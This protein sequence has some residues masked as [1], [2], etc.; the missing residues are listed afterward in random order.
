MPK[1]YCDNY[2]LHQSILD[3]VS[4]LAENVASTL[5]PKGR[6]VIIRSAN[7]PPVVTK[8]GVTIA[9]FVAFEDPF[10]DAGAQIV[11]QAA[12]QTNEE[13]GD[14]TTTSTVL[15]YSILNKAQRYV[16]SGVSP[17]ELK[18]GM[19]KACQII[20][21][22]IK[23]NSV[24]ITSKQDIENVAKISANGD[25]VIGSL[26]ATAIDQAGKN[27]SVSIEEARSI[28]TSLELIEGFSFDSGYVSPQFI[29]NER[30]SAVK[31]EDC[32]IFITN[33]KLDAIENMLP[34]LELAAR[35]SRPLVIIADEIEG[36]FLAALIA[37]AIRGTMRVVAIKSP[38]YGEERL[39]ILEDLAVSTGATFFKRNG[40]LPLKDVELKHF[41]K[42]KM[43][44]VLKNHTTIV[45]GKGDFKKIE[46]RIE[47][48]KEEVKQESA[49]QICQR[50]QER[51]TRL[52]S[53]VAVIYVGASTQ[54]EMIE[55]K[56]RIEDALEAVRSAQIDGIHAGGGVPLVKISK[57]IDVPEA[58]P[59][60]QKIGFRIILE[61]CQEP[62]KQMAKNAG[63]SPD[64]IVAKV[65]E[66]E[67][68]I[69]WN[70]SSG[71]L[72]NMLE[73]GIVDPTRVTCSAL[74][75]AVS[76][77]STLITTNYAII[78]C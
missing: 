27:G 38:R 54:V 12:T 62:I 69:G 24:Q 25:E 63:D 7:K 67:D 20:I 57:Q 39:G 71:E 23:S 73:E 68:G 10:E 46:E 33:H 41:G 30:K 28:E 45:G 49:I 47:K 32:L 42:A 29:T 9:K 17:I 35:E 22:H 40:T 6:N 31:Y 4:K 53:G 5:G 19:D 44:E 21:E 36:Q 70:F 26:V 56:H 74:R 61:A 37:N 58:L 78:D 14:G 2:E 72:V 34:T 18:R 43:V 52:A 60:E 15:S 50:I 16:R 8:D 76:V 66:S 51:I 64:L 11:K 13:A 1:R 77:A 75:N 55:K 48:L 3:G 65:L 59:E